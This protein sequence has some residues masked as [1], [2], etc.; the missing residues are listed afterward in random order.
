VLDGGLYR[1]LVD[2]VA[3]VHSSRKL[4]EPS[5]F[6]GGICRACMEGCHGDS[7][8]PIVELVIDSKLVGD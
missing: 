8:K 1:L 6:E 2:L 4:D 5:S 7:S 3:L